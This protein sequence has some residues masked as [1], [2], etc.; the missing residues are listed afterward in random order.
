MTEDDTFNALRRTPFLDVWGKCL[1]K[2]VN[3]FHSLDAQDLAQHIGIIRYSCANDTVAPRIIEQLEDEGWAC[4]EVI[5]W[6]DA[7]YELTGQCNLK[8]KYEELREKCKEQQ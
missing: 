2:N 3:Y 1:R 6:I 7:R 8:Y 5:K 4:D